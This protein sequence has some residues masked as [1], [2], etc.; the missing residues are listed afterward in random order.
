MTYKQFMTV[1]VKLTF[2]FVYFCFMA[3]SDAADDLPFLQAGGEMAEL[4]RGFNWAG[5]SLGPLSLWPPA[6]KII[7]ALLL[8]SRFPMLLCWGPDYIQLYNDAFR[9]VNGRDKHPKALGSSARETYAEIWETIGPM[10]E[11]VMRG[12]SFGFPDFNVRLERNG[13]PED[14]YFDFS[15]S[16][17]TD[18]QGMIRGILVICKETTEKVRAID[19]QSSLAEEM[20]AMN[21]ELA[22]ANEE[23]TAINEELIA[24]NEELHQHQEQLRASLESVA[25][26]ERLFKSIA[27]NIPRSLIIVIG[28]DHRFL[29]IEGDLMTRMG[30]D[31]RDYQGKH[32]LEVG[33]A[34]RYEASRHLYDQVLAGETFSVERKGATGEDFIVHFVPLK[35]ERDEVYAGLIIALDITAIRQA[36]EKSARLAAIVESSADAIISK[37][38]DSVITSWNQGAERMFGYTEA[39]M[40]GETIYKLI[41]PERHDEE[42]RI[43]ARLK[44]GHR[45][46]HF[47]TQRLTKDG[48]LLE[49]SLS[50]S[51][52]KDPQGRIIG[53]SKIARDITE[54]KLD[55]QRKNDFI[56][57]VSHE[58]KT[59][60]TSLGAIIQVADAKLRQ[61]ED[62]FLAGAMQKAIIQIKRM[63][64]MINGFLNISRLESGKI[65]ID[66]AHF[67]LQELIEEMIA[68]SELTISS[69]TIRFQGCGA[70]RILADRDKMASV[71]TNLISNAVKYSPKGK[72]IEVSCEV[73]DRSVQISV[74]DQG[75]GIKPNDLP[76]V[77][78]RYYR[79]S[80]THTQH[81]SG[82]GIGLY[83]SA[84]IIRHHGGDIWAESQSGA[85][86]TFYFSLPLVE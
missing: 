61:S 25:R 45:V 54:R 83:L 37:T 65:Q 56:G 68:E 9:P 4:I 12:E 34:E 15:Y 8:S 59:P 38:F 24:T 44:D 86:S 16:P 10:F 79:V 82:F 17:L 3:N 28:P 63:T 57:M 26:S 77:F 35:N 75:M 41:P 74:R 66:K 5:T 42:P 46:E 84:E 62:T 73:N 40:I 1:I 14:C 11:A 51:P 71:L 39:E 60:L 32:P 55:E 58:L 6:L 64:G 48:R 23:Y 27:L 81:I 85:G 33:P 53:L 29:T 50:I 69:H 13:Y 47:D 72:L 67:D 36:E 76:H 80:T 30:Y 43:L 22:A 70:V 49:V 18:E 31:S 52:V 2:P 7:T 21:E 20:T 19:E 78:D